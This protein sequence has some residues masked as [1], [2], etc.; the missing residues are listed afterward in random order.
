[1]TRAR[2]E[3]ADAVRAGDSVADVPGLLRL[4]LAV[5][6]RLGRVLLRRPDGFAS[7]PAHLKVVVSRRR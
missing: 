6:S 1:M 5:E 2:E 7:L 4:V 3:R